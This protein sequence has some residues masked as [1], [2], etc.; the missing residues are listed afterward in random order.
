M[1][2]THCA[3]VRVER[4][5]NISPPCGSSAAAGTAG[6]GASQPQLTAPSLSPGQAARRRERLG[7]A[8]G[9]TAGLWRSLA[10]GCG[11]IENC[12]IV[13]VSTVVSAKGKEFHRVDLALDGTVSGWAVKEGPAR[14]YF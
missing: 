6:K 12:K 3:M 10:Q 5:T 1:N 14:Y 2:D 7:L 9:S 4:P 13:S 8:P 11:G